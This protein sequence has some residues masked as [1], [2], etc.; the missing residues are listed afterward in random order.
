MKSALA[1]FS[2]CLQIITLSPLAK[3]YC[4]AALQ[5]GPTHHWC[6]VSLTTSQQLNFGSP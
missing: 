5:R 1:L 6:A 2:F 4:A 3:D